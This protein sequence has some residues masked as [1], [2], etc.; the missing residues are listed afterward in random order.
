MRNILEGNLC[1]SL[2]GCLHILIKSKNKIATCSSV[3]SLLRWRDTQVLAIVID[4]TATSMQG[5]NL[6]KI[7]VCYTDSSSANIKN[8]ILE[9]Y[10]SW[11]NR[12][13]ELISNS[14]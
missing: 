4:S 9:N 10:S 14:L 3:G 12:N 7:I 2:H 1:I 8:M 5:V 11:I 6:V 13:F